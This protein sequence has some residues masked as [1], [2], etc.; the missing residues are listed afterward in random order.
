ISLERQFDLLKKK[1]TYLEEDFALVEHDRNK[2][3]MI[4]R[5]SIPQ[6]LEHAVNYYEVLL[7]AGNQLSFGR[8]EFDKIIGKR[9]VRPANLARDTFVRLLVDFESLFS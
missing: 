5:S 4:L 7:E 9:R 2:P 8:Y 1:I 3:M 6:Q